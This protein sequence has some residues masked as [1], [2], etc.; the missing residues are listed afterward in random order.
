[1]NAML[2]FANPT[3]HVKKWCLAPTPQSVAEILELARASLRRI[4]GARRDGSG[5]AGPR[6][7]LRLVA[8]RGRRP[9]QG[10]R[11]QGTGQSLPAH[12][13]AEPV[14]G[15]VTVAPASVGEDGCIDR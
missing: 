11:L 3:Y 6:G 10:G 7:L 9:A 14:L 5:K 1:M 12:G 15:C 13:G 2:P 8:P 4:R